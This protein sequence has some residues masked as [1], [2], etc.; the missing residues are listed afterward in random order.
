MHDPQ[1]SNRQRRRRIAI[2]VI[3]PAVLAGVVGASAASLGGVT[4]P[5]L[6]ADV[7]TVSS[8]DT[9]G[10]TLAYTNSYDSTLGRYQTTSVA[11]S[12]INVACNTKSISVTLKDSSS[13]SLGSGSA[14]VSAGA[15][16]I[17][18]SGSGANASSVTGVAVIIT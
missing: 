7:A 4:S 16:T 12:G 6:G 13:A 3:A 9:D 15:A 1:V 2:A 14:T 11:V 17:T 5:S 8:C 10:V 18:L